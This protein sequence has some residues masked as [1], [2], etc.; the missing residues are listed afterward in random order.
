MPFDPRNPAPSLTTTAGAA[1]RLSDL[2]RRIRALESQRGGPFS[3]QFIIGD[4]HIVFTNTATA[5][6]DIVHGQNSYPP[7]W[8]T[9]DFADPGFY[10]IYYVGVDS[11]PDVN[12]A[13]LA[14]QTDSGFQYTGSKHFFWAVLRP[15]IVQL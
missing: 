6:I 9:Y 13:R 3:A 4:G 7:I 1:D 8:V 14:F 15:A 5:L 10:S 2:D 12:T 11:Y